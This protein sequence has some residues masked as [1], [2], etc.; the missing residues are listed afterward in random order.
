MVAFETVHYVILMLFTVLFGTRQSKIIDLRI[1]ARP[2]H[3]RPE[4]GVV[5]I[6]VDEDG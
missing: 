6:E 5:R 2:H 1:I 4:T 3:P